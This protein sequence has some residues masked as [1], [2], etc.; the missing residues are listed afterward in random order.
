MKLKRKIFIVVSGVI[1]VFFYLKYNFI[2]DQQTLMTLKSKAG[3]GELV[4]VFNAL[5]KIESLSNPI[6]NLLF[7]QWKEKMNNRFILNN[8]TIEN[9]SGNKIVNDISNIYR[10]YWKSE[11]LKE[12]AD[13]RTDSILYANIIEYLITNQLTNQSSAILSKTIRND[14][15]LK[16]IIQREGFKTKFIFR[17]G[18]QDLLIWNNESDYHY[19]VALPH[20]TI[21]TKVIFIENYYLNGFDN[22]ASL[23]SAQIGGWSLE[24]SATLYCN[25]DQYDLNSEKFEI[26][27]LKHE[28]LH[29]LDLNRYPNLSTTDLE[30]RSKLIELIYCTENTIYN[31]LAEFLNGANSADRDYSHPYA[32]YILIKN[33]SQLLF[34]DDYVADWTNWRG[35]SVEEINK[36]AVVLFERSEALLLKDRNIEEVI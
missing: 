1:A 25:K 2:K 22:Y 10:S 6:V 15:E 5:E 8:E 28:S 34:G 36:A 14:S 21:N 11:L 13:T 24:E 7:L 9:T 26:S 20:D 17:N 29:F 18:L 4:Y 32:N 19:L 3:N 30:Y 12:Y 33:L 27:Y 23:G 35:I 16:R 31:R